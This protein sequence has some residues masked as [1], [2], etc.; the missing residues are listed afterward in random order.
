M[1]TSPKPSSKAIDD[2]FPSKPY[3]LTS[4]PNPMPDSSSSSSLLRWVGVR[5]AQAFD[6]VHDTILVTS[7]K[8]NFCFKKKMDTSWNRIFVLTLSIKAS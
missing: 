5:V 6:G 7:K 4:N 2:G 3:N 8:M 1:V